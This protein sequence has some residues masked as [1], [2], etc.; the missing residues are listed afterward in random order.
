MEGGLGGINADGC[1]TYGGNLVSKIFFISNIDVASSLS[2]GLGRIEF[3]IFVIIVV[4]VVFFAVE[5][6]V[7]V[8]N[9]VFDSSIWPATIAA[10][11]ACAAVDN[12]GF[13]EGV[14][15]S[16]CD[17]PGGFD[18]L[19]SRESPAGTALCLILDCVNDSLFTPVEG[20]WIA[21]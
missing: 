4:W 3:A 17:S 9:D 7:L 21:D 18:S 20:I 5:S 6:T 15:G 2:I 16:V 10:I 13:G 14:K 8:A 19:D 1:N 12:V 11:A